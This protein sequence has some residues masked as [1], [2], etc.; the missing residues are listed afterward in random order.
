MFYKINCD[1]WSCEAP[2]FVDSGSR[3]K[4]TPVVNMLSNV[5][6]QSRTHGIPSGG[7][8]NL[9]ARLGGARPGKLSGLLR[10]AY[11]IAIAQNK[12]V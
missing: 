5:T 11:V 1:Q 4:S 9:G 10:Q 6:S 12:T 7:G 3:P 8:V 2:A